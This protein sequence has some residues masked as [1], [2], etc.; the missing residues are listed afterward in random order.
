MNDSEK[1]AIW[2][3]RKKIVELCHQSIEDL[4][5]HNYES[6]VFSIKEIENNI[7]TF[8]KENAV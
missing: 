8:Y 6:T 5:R 2:A 3:I 4:A 7:E 1:E